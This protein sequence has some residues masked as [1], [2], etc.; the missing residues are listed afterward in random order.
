V[1]SAVKFNHKPGLM[2]DEVRNISTERDLAPEAVAAEP[3]S[4]K[5]LPKGALGVGHSAAHTL[6]KGALDIGDLT[7]R[8]TPLPNPP[9]QGGRGR[10]EQAAQPH[11]NSQIQLHGS[12]PGSGEMK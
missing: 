3:M 9:P 5:P 10:A 6:G 11:P 2:A 12:P 8:H 4:A 1:L 7:V